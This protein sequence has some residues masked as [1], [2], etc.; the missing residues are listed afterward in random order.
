MLEL[1]VKERSILKRFF[2]TG[3]YVFNFSTS[4]FDAFT[5]KSIGI[6]LCEKYRLSKGKSLEAFIDEANTKLIILL[7]SDLLDYYE[8]YEDD[9]SEYAKK[10]DQL[11]QVRSILHNYEYLIDK[12]GPAPIDEDDVGTKRHFKMK[13][14][15][16][17]I[18]HASKDKLAAVNDIKNEIHALGV[19]VWYDADRIEWGDSLSAVIDNGLQRC[20]FGII[21]ISRSYFNSKWCNRELKTLV[22]RNFDNGRKVILPLLLNVTISEAIK[23]YPFLED[24]KMVEYKKGQEKDIALLFAQVLIGRLK[25]C[26]NEVPV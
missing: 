1:T 15:D 6:K 21:V 23:K 9:L 4:A 20:E 3:G 16:V 10:P 11:Q 7:T 14:Y 17:F 5:Y 2:N 25:E 24:I 26:C 12:L 13:P 8:V 22:D 18:S 19:N